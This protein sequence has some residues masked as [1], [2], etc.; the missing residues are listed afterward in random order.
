MLGRLRMRVEDCL[1]R[2]PD[3]AQSVFGKKRS[4]FTRLRDLSTTKYDSG[5]LETAVKTI[6]QGRVPKNEKR[7]P[8][9]KGYAF[10]NF[11]SPDDLC[12]T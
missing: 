9:Q 8:R 3:L 12:R 11:S 1:D 2:Y 6:V 10:H 4:Y 5:K 7:K